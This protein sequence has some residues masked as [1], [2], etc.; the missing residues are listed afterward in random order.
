M[1]AALM[2][3]VIR[4]NGLGRKWVGKEMGWIVFVVCGLSY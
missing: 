1:M 3:E 4:E 2:G